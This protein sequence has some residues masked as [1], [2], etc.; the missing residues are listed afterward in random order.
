M[1]KDMA[2]KEFGGHFNERSGMKNENQHQFETEIQ[3]AR[4]NDC[5]P[6]GIRSFLGDH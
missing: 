6:I 3:C 4:Y 1:S 2:Q 5:Q